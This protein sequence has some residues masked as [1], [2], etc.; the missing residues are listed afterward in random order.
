MEC[1]QVI[2]AKVVTDARN[3]GARCYGFITML[4]PEN[5]TECISSLNQ[6]ELNGQT[7]TVEMVSS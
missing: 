5:A 1:I 4:V 7:I 2:C 6:S 3:P